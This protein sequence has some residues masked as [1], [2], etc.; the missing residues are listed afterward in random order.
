MKLPLTCLSL[1]AN[2]SYGILTCNKCY[3]SNFPQVQ[4]KIKINF[5]DKEIKS[6]DANRCKKI[7]IF[8]PAVII[9]DSS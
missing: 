5:K 8:F 2:V 1:L 3:Q 4:S 7:Y 9:F 6:R